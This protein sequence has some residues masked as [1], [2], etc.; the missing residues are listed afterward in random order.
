MTHTTSSCC[1]WSTFQKKE[2]QVN[3]V[4]YSTATE[5]AGG[6][7]GH[8]PTSIRRTVACVG[9]TCGTGDPSTVSGSLLQ[10]LARTRWD[11]KPQEEGHALDYSPSVSSQTL[12][13]V[14]VG[15]AERHIVKVFPKHQPM[16]SK[17][18]LLWGVDLN[19]LSPLVRTQSTGSPL[20][21][22]LPG[23]SQSNWRLN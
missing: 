10:S 17:T 22:W 18:W 7:A 3:G 2:A 4:A 15:D 8:T 9:H 14:K 6:R 23:G 1:Y 19:V 12:L 20:F 13:L 16:G 11:L 21:L 5:L